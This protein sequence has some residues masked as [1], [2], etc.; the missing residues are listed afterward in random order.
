S[1]SHTSAPAYTLRLSLINDATGDS[2]RIG[3][4]SGAPIAA[5]LSPNGQWLAYI[6]QKGE[7]GANEVWALHLTDGEVQSLGCSSSAPFTDRLAWSPDSQF[8]AY[9]LVGIDLGP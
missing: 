7:T 6:T 8:L 9:T 2:I 4:V 5:S 1:L 3:D